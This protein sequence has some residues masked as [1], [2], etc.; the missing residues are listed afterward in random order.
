MVLVGEQQIQ[1][2]I[3]PCIVGSAKDTPRSSSRLMSGYTSLA[4][5][6]AQRT[7]LLRGYLHQRLKVVRAVLSD[8]LVQKQA[9]ARS[10][11]RGDCL[12]ILMFS[13]EAPF[14]RI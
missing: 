1:V 7:A 12:A 13:H 5:S 9:Q 8:D 10:A 3:K 4:I 14:E 6:S 2:A 11:S